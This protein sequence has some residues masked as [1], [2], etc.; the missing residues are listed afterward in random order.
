[1]EGRCCYCRP[2]N[3]LQQAWLPPRTRS[4]TTK[5]PSTA[6]VRTIHSS[7]FSTENSLRPDLTTTFSVA[8]A[9]CDSRIALLKSKEAECW[10]GE[11]KKNPFDTAGH[12]LLYPPHNALGDDHPG[13]EHSEI[14]DPF[15]LLRARERRP[16]PHPSRSRLT[17]YRRLLYIIYLIEII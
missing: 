9:Q 8:N 17:S 6:V 3:C 5:T 4:P 1:M 2:M 11:S 10:L 13:Y 14:H 15:L 16:P 12:C 7:P